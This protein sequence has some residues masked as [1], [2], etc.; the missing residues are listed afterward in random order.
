MIDIDRRHDGNVA[1]SD[2]GR[3]PTAAH[4]HLDDRHIDGRVGEDGVGEHDEDLEER[5][6]GATLGSRARVDDLDDRGHLVPGL[7]QHLSRHGLTVDGDP[8]PHGVQVWGGESACAQT[9]FA[10]QSLDH[11]GGRGLAVRAGQV[12]DPE[13]ALRVAQ[14]FHDRRDPIEGRHEVVFGGAAHDLGLHLSQAGG[15][16]GIARGRGH[17]CS[18]SHRSRTTQIESGMPSPVGSRW[19]STKPKPW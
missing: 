7:H 3:I 13:A 4:P 1:V 19:D 16:R 10:A 18:C 14:Q 15:H 8:L 6:P 12:D 5:H 2:I 9:V 17:D 11:A